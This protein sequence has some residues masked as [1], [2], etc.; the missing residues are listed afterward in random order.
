[1]RLETLIEG[2]DKTAVALGAFAVL[3]TVTVA[4]TPGDPQTKAIAMSMLGPIG[5]GAAGMVMPG[6][7]R[8]HRYRLEA[9]G[10]AEKSVESPEFS[11]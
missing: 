9:G 7:G 1:M 5:G 6:A 2:M 3:G 4:L 10:S 11:D 8:S